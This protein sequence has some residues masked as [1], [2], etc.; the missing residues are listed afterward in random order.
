MP[1]YYGQNEL[2]RV[3]YERYFKDKKNGFFVECGAADGLLDVTCKFFEDTMGWTGI[4]IEPVERLYK[5]LLINRPNCKNIEGALSNEHKRV[6]FTELIYK[7]SE[8]LPIGLGSINLHT[9]K[10][11]DELFKY[12]TYQVIC[13]KFSQLFTE[14]RLIDLFVLD[15]EGHELEAIDGILEI[16]QQFYPIIFCIE[17]GWINTDRLQEKLSP[18]YTLDM[19]AEIDM[20]FKRKF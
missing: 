10:I 16:P 1:P 18:F 20:Y 7:D 14:P 15:V 9:G 4:N 13:Y 8:G 11:E 19:D 6:Y 5:Q 3:L 17:K 2:D 12:L